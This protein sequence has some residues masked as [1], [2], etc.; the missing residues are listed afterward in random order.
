[1]WCHP[2]SHLLVA[3]GS[4]LEGARDNVPEYGPISSMLTHFV[5][6]SALEDAQDAALGAGAAGRKSP[7]NNAAEAMGVKPGSME[8]GEA[9]LPIC[10]TF[11]QSVRICNNV[12]PMQSLHTYVLVR[13]LKFASVPQPL[14]L[15]APVHA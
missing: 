13:A 6:V 1:M 7:G 14:V 9:A 11:K 2:F 8:E 4:R 15:V 12:K 5:L 10:H 3:Q